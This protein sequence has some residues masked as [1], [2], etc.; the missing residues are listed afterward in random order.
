VLV[1]EHPGQAG[2]ADRAELH[3]LV[4]EPLGDLPERGVLEGT[5]REPVLHHRRLIGLLHLPEDLAR[6]Q[7]VAL[8][9]A[10]GGVLMSLD[11]AEPLDG[12]EEP[13]FAA[14]RQVEAAVAVRHDVEARGLLGI[15][16]GG[17]GVEILLAE[18]R[19]AKGGLE[20]PA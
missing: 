18:H 6:A 15:D 7:V 13:G 14:H 11:A 10:P 19:V 9:P 20:R 2:R 17:H 1:P 3:G 12:I 5:A 8:H 16:D 4:G